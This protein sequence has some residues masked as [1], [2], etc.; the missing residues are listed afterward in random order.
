MDE[1][2]DTISDIW[3]NTNQDYIK[4]QENDL[5]I[6]IDRA[7]AQGKT[8]TGNGKDYFDLVP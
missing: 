6:M 5:Q 1:F 8:I 7:N 3:K 2:K 4:Q